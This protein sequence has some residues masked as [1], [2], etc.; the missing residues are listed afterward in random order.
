MDMVAKLPLDAAAWPTV[1]SCV[2]KVLNL[3]QFLIA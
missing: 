3:G 2:E 1:R